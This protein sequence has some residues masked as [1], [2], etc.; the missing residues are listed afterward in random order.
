MH[1]CTLE[2]RDFTHTNLDT[3]SRNHTQ[4]YS[5]AHIHSLTNTPGEIH[6]LTQS[7]ASHQGGHSQIRMPLA[8]AG[9]TAFLLPSPAA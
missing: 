3:W 8:P 4:V 1:S 7:Q 9:H 5:T 6:S 2:F